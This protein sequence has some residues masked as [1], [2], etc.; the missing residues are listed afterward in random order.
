MLSPMFMSTF[1]LCHLSSKELDK[2]GRE[3]VFTS[4]MSESTNEFRESIEFVVLFL[5]RWLP[6]KSKC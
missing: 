4:N 5:L 2:T 1:M 3:R 6:F